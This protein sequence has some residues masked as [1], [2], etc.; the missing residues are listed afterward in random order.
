MKDKKGKFGKAEWYT[1]ATMLTIF[2]L[3]I[4]LWA[5][6]GSPDQKV[7]EEKEH[8]DY[9]ELPKNYTAAAPNIE[10]LVT[11]N[12]SLTD[13]HYNILTYQEDG[14]ETT[15]YSTDSLIEESGENLTWAVF[16]FEINNKTFIYRF[17]ASTVSD[18]VRMDL[19]YGN[20][21]MS[22][23]TYMDD[24]MDEREAYITEMENWLDTQLHGEVQN[25]R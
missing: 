25:E 22:L 5:W 1:I 14:Q 8:I 13:F 15:H 21:S 7:E 18:T 3:I 23:H 19:W 17:E 4:A 10:S 6:Q 20:A 16:N 2:L 9:E 11:E 12:D 24:Y